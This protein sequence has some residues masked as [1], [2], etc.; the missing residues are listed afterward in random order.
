M[1]YIEIANA[2]TLQIKDNWDGKE[3]LVTLAAAFMNSVRL[4]D[5]V[6]LN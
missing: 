6:I 4:I 1:D 5:N 3:K 2:D